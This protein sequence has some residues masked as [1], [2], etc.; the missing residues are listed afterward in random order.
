MK[1]WH[2]RDVGH[3]D[4]PPAKSGVNPLAIILVLAAIGVALAVALR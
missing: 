1:P 4:D 3:Q 2:Q